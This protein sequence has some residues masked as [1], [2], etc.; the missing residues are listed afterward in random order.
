MEITKKKIKKDQ[1]G[2]GQGLGWIRGFGE[3]DHTMGQENDEWC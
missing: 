3:H 1:G 2:E